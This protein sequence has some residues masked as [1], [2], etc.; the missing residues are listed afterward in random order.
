MF[1]GVIKTKDV[2]L[3]PLTLMKMRGFKG[4]MKLIVRA[5]SPRRYRFVGMTQHTQWIHVDKKQ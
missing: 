4:L 2:L 1:V 3:H 5:L